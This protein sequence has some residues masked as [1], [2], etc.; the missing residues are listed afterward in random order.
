MN[1]IQKAEALHQHNVGYLSSDAIRLRLETSEL[2][3]NIRS[4]L[5]GKEIITIQ[6]GA[7]IKQK[8]L[9]SGDTAKCND[10]GAAHLVNYVSSII[11][12]AVVQGNYTDD[13]YRERIEVTHKRLAY[14][15]IV[16]KHEWEIREDSMH[17]IVGF[18][19]E[20]VVPFLS[21]LIDN[22]ERKSYAATMRTSESSSI[23]QKP[24]GLAGHFQ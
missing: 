23:R 13:W 16:H 20:L 8:E 2:L 17:S 19:M 11:N 9:K 21:R 1:E 10:M 7:D 24:P 22:E 4:F 5:T 12:P 15:L 6:E 14:M 18:I 3:A